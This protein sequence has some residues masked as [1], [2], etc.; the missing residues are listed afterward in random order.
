MS[1]KDQR[2]VS[3]LILFNIETV[4]NKTQREKKEDEITLL[5]MKKICSFILSELKL[6]GLREGENISSQA[7]K[8]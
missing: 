1:N 8:Y 2:V 3:L 7:N 4:R 6:L 5:P